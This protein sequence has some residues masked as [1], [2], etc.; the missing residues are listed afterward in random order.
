M[1]KEEGAAQSAH[2]LVVS[3]SPDV[4]KSPTTPIP[5]TIVAYLSN[6]TM[7]SPDVSIRSS[8]VFHMDSVVATVIGD[9]AGVGGGVVS[10]VNK[11]CC[12]PLTAS[13]TV[14]SNGKFVCRHETTL[15]EMNC[16]GPKG[17]G[18]TVGKLVYLGAMVPGPK[19]SNGGVLDT[20]V[21]GVLD[22]L[23]KS[24]DLSAEKIIKLTGIATKMA[25]MDWSDPSAILGQLGA[26]AGQ[27]GFGDI[28]A[29][30]SKAKEAV[31]L[32]ELD[33][34]DPA[35]VLGAV[36][37]H[38]APWLEE[39]IEN[40][41]GSGP[42]LPP[43]VLTAA[44]VYGP[45]P[46]YEAME[47]CPSHAP[48]MDNLQDGWKPYFGVTEVFHCGYDGI[49]EDVSASPSRPQNECFYDE[50]GALVT[51]SSAYGGCRGT[52]NLYDGK[53]DKYNHTMHDP[54]GIRHAGGEGLA[55]SVEKAK[56]DAAEAIGD[57]AEAVGDAVTGV[58]D[59]VGGVF[60]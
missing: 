42:E 40:A 6:A 33:W 60:E 29:G 49:L 48:D 13:T 46:N 50:T 41:G 47:P 34:S 7:T 19:A 39:A 12:R 8:P 1:A 26:L 10:G 5:Y 21:Q 53:T 58:L 3:Q 55:T 17:V 57:A 51:Q 2:Y 27:T 45:Q 28:A 59:D 32:A 22:Q 25:T 37:P 11:G 52:P 56:D 23:V 44:P 35:A 9:E 24:L 31:D 38:V 15:M 30:L 14:R 20:S 4:C 36:G 54:G 43:G 18:N 16:A